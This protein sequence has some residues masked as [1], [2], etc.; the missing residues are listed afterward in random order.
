VLEIDLDA[1]RPPK[2][3]S[4]EYFATYYAEIMMILLRAALPG[5]EASYGLAS[6]SIRHKFSG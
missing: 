5:L 2:G 6:T 3:I 4:H 1:F